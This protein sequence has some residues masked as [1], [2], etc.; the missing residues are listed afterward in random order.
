MAAPISS[1]SPKR[2]KGTACAMRASTSAGDWPVLAAL[3]SAI[4]SKRAVR[5]APGSTLFTVMPSGPS[6]LAR[7]LAQLATAPRTV[8]ETPRPSRGCLTDVE[9]TLTMRPPPAALMPGNTA[10][11][12]RWLHMRCW[13][14]AAR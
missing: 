6:S 14:K 5:V 9:I 2:R 11:T 10:W 1:A 3:A 7:V 12:N 13:V 4:W 8:L